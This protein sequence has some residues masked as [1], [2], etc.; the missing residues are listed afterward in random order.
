ME[1]IQFEGLG[2]PKSLRKNVDVSLLLQK[3]DH[4]T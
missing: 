4:E 3:T 2:E 1:N